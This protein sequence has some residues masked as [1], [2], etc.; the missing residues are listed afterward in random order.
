MWDVM[1]N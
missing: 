1:K